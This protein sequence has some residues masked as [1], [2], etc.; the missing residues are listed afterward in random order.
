MTEQEIAPHTI[1][2][3]AENKEIPK[4]SRLSVCNTYELI[5]DVSV[6]DPERTAIVLPAGEEQADQL[7]RAFSYGAL[8]NGVHQTANLL[9]DL[10]VEPGDVIAL[11]VPNLLEAHLLL[12]GGQTV[13]IVCP[14]PLELPVE[15]IIALLREVRAKVLVAPGPEASQ[16]LWQKAEEIRRDVKSITVALQVRGPGQERDAVYAFN[17]LLRDYS[18]SHL[19]IQRDIFPND[20]AIFLPTSSTTGMPSLISLTHGDLLYLAR[21]IGTILRLAPEDVLLRSLLY[22]IQ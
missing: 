21:A 15:Q 22:F 12:W 17:A 18:A 6:R 10:A 2:D 11:L 5:R 20:V 14:V 13:G 9:A 16:D 19:H 1:E 7:G 8:L 3:F 4:I